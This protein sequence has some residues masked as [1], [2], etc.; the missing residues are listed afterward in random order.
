MTDA[1]AMQQWNKVPR[2]KEAATSEEGGDIRQDLQED[3]RAG[4][5]RANIRVFDWATGS[6]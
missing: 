5:R 1:P 4:G 3:R 6:E 2:L